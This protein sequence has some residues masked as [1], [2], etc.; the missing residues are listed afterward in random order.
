MNKN[1][2]KLLAEKLFGPLEVPE[3]GYQY[4][5]EDETKIIELQDDET[6][7]WW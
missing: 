7:M 2:L 3:V 4:D 1:E 5:Q 6:R